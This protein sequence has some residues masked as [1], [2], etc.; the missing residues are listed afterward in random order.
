MMEKLGHRRAF[1]RAPT[2]AI[3]NAPNAANYDEA[4]AQSLPG[5]ARS[6][7]TGQRQAG[8]VPRRT[9]G[10]SAARNSWSCSTA[11]STAA[12]R[13]TCPRS[14][15]RSSDRAT[16]RRRRREAVCSAS[17]SATSTTPAI[18]LINVDIEVELTTPAGAKGVPVIIEFFPFEFGGAHSAAPPPPTWQ[19]QVIARGWA[20][21]IL[22]P[23]STSRPT[24]APGSP[25]GIIGLVNK[26]QPREPDDWG[27]LQRLGL[28]RVARCS[29]IWKPIRT[30]MRN[31]P[32]SRACRA[33]ARRRW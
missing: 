23:S 27:A 25:R 17:S 12:C 20:Y 10:R 13:S 9:G 4:K 18:P 19:E 8:E 33:S 7:E 31:A 5:A 26:G 32:S 28:G 2:A 15:G 24:T 16:R 14:P 3:P 1:A 6:A 30:W 21:A 11:R 22:S 29:T